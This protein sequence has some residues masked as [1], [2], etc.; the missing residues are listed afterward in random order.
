MDREFLGFGAELLV[1]GEEVQGFP[2]GA[3]GPEVE[4][5]VAARGGDFS[6]S[7]GW[8]RRADC[9]CFEHDE[10][11]EFAGEGEEGAGLGCGGHDGA[12]YFTR[13]GDS[14][15]MCMYMALKWVAKLLNYCW[16]RF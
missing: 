15:E 11:S 12:S 5:A 7:A 13:G 6:T 8:G 4:L 9:E 1:D 16:S 14:G 3:F 10:I 2:I